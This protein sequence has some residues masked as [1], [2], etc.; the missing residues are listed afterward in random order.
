MI[1]FIREGLEWIRVDEHYWNHVY[2]SG[3]QDQQ[4]QANI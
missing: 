4:L 3:V 1:V 2:S